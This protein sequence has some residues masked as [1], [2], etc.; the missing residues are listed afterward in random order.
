MKIMYKLGATLLLCLAAGCVNSVKLTV[1]AANQDGVPTFNVKRRGGNGL[2][3]LK[4]WNADTRRPLWGVS[5]N[6]FPGG[7]VTYGKVPK[8]F[9]IFNGETRNAVQEF[10]VE[11]EEPVPLSINSRFYLSFVYQYDRIYAPSTGRAYFTF[12]TDHQG[13]I[14]KIVPVERLTESEPPMSDWKGARP[15]TQ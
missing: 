2:L 4:I 9:R 13:R 8:S 3:Y 14:S 12:V 15:S 7:V 11:S 1:E 5:L 6:Y 10:P